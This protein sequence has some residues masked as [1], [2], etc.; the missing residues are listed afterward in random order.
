[1]RS[2]SL[3]ANTSLC[4]RNL[5]A[6]GSATLPSLSFASDPDTG[7]YLSGTNTLGIAVGGALGYSFSPSGFTLHGTPLLSTGAISVTAGGANQNITLT[8]SGTGVAVISTASVSPT[9][10]IST[11]STASAANVA[12]GLLN[13]G[14]ASAASRSWQQI[15]NVSSN[16]RLEFQ[17]SSS[18]STAPSVAV[19]TLTSGDVAIFGTT[20]D[21]SNGRIQLA[22][23]TT[24][25]GGI[26]FGTDTPLW[27]STGGTLR[28]GDAGNDIASLVLN[29]SGGSAALFSH[30]AASVSLSANRASGTLTLGTTNATDGQYHRPYPR[31]LAAHDFGGRAEA[32]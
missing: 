1:M 16:G 2:R 27:R 8:P 3:F 13:Q 19:M 5:F 11:S 22:T 10:N 29:G 25:A 15:T 20:T 12:L 18:N 7:V 21:S 28:F 24:S 4:Q 6:A 14:A 32:A 30:A 31:L 9:L 17:R 23:H 26:G